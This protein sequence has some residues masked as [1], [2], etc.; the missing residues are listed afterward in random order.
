MNINAFGTDIFLRF[1]VR[2]RMQK[3]KEDDK[4]R[5]LPSFP[6]FPC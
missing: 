2:N 5:L 6:P 1:T 3:I 4:V